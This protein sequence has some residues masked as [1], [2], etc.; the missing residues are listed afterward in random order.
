MAGNK[1]FFSIFIPSR[2][3]SK[4]EKI[5][6]IITLCAAAVFIVSICILSAYLVEQSKNR[7]LNERLADE[8]TASFTVITQATT[9]PPETETEVVTTAPPPLVVLGNMESF[10]NENGHTA[11]WI[12]VPNTNVNNVVVQA[13][14]N[15]YYL[16]KNYYGQK[17]K[18]GTV[19]ADFRCI[20]NDYNNKQSDNII[21]YGHN[22]ADGSMFGTL[23]KY[24]LTHQNTRNFQFYLD[25]PTFTFSNLYEEYTYKIIAIFIIEVEEYQNPNGIIFDYHNYIKFVPNARSFDSFKENILSRTEIDT[26]VDFEQ[27][28]KFVT[29]ST[30]SNEFEPSRFV[31]IGR[32]V[33]DGEDPAVD[34][35]KALLNEDAIEPDL[36]F[37]YNR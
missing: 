35:S 3:D 20:V 36:N 34:T 23:K 32:R 19:Y 12:T 14:D 17:S 6:K 16:D 31:V 2:K 29:L 30:C 5:R 28:D 22:Q 37:I 8:H 1:N 25:N 11:G 33:R 7:K 13:E 18:A 27:G 15:E 9:A 10:L 26:G 24:K 21:L 4:N